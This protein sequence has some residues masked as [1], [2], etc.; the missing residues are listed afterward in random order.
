MAA[1]P[2]SIAEVYAER[3]HEEKFVRGFV[4]DWAK[5]MNAD[6]YDASWA[7]YHA[8]QRPELAQD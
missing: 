3:G 6:R 4:K 1:S 8:M 5:V 7:K 2:C